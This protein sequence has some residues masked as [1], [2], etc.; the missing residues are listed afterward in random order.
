MIVARTYA[1]TKQE[2]K[3]IKEYSTFSTS[4][5]RVARE[6]LVIKSFMVNVARFG[7]CLHWLCRFESIEEVQRSLR[8]SGLESSELILCLDLTKS[9]EWSGTES[10]SPVFFYFGMA[11]FLCHCNAMSVAL[12]TNY[13]ITWCHTEQFIS[14]LTYSAPCA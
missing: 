11:A 2:E 1:R 9:N 6:F 4:D 12:C 7:T 5:I 8:E 14:F 13:I 3:D 10:V